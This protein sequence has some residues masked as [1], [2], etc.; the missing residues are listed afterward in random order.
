M[1][2]S[3]WL[4]QEMPIGNFELRGKAW[5]KGPAKNLHSY[6][7]RD[8][9]ILTN[10]NA[11]QKIKDKWFKTQQTFDFYF[12]RSPKASQY[13]QEGVV[14]PEWIKEKIGEDIQPRSDTITVIF[15]NN[16]GAEKIPMTAWAMAHRFGHAISGTREWTDFQREVNYY[17]K[18][19]FDNLYSFQ[20]NF[21]S[22][23]D[24]DS[25]AKTQKFGQFLANGIG[26]M[27]SARDN[28]IFRFGEF[29]F[30]LLAQYLISGQIKFNVP[31]K[32]LGKSNFGRP[33]LR[34]HPDAVDNWDQ[35]SMDNVGEYLTHYAESLVGSMVNKMF[36]M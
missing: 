14:T 31:P 35:D 11:V 17:L 32:Q 23:Y 6:D 33:T 24:R 15:T 34:A 20:A 3:E 27:K 28:K 5:E 16:V 7:R 36:V 30:E 19:I 4:L 1:K 18:N 10:D 8:V 26:T 22:G 2:F 9:G 12:V 21:G 29:Y 25:Y 13:R